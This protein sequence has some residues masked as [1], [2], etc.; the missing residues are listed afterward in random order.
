L[1]F[2]YKHC[3]KKRKQ[4]T[5]KKNAG[6]VNGHDSHVQIDTMIYGLTLARFA[7]ASTQQQKLLRRFIVASQCSMSRLSLSL[8]LCEMR[9]TIFLTSSSFPLP[10]QMP[11]VE[12]FIMDTLSLA[13]TGGP[14]GYRINL[15][16][17][18]VFGASNFTV[19]SIVYVA[20]PCCFRATHAPLMSD[21]FITDWARVRNPSRRSSPFRGSSLKPSTGAA[22]F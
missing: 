15:K 3:Q 9:E 17:M 7:G 6:S 16:D 22:A 5:R 1:R 21:T 14:N 20:P 12:P 18:E 19:K 4:I 10:F 8:S 11:S 13:L 2:K